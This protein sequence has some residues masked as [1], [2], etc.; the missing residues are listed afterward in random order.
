MSANENYG[1]SRNVPRREF[2]K[3]LLHLAIETT[4]DVHERGSFRL[5]S[6]QSMPDS[7][8]ANLTPK[9]TEGCEISVQGDQVWATLSILLFPSELAYLTVF[10]CFDGQ[11]TLDDC[12]SALADQMNWSYEEAFRFAKDLL[13][14]LAIRQVCIPT[15]PP[16]YG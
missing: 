15:N 10:N 16:E 6:L 14:D 1:A 7:S 12:A 8:I 13:I 2:V 4:K 5:D 9:V 3:N 11:H